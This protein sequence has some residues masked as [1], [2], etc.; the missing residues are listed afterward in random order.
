M[1]LGVLSLMASEAKALGH[2]FSPQLPSALDLVSKVILVSTFLPSYP[3]SIWLPGQSS[4][5][6]RDTGQSSRASRDMGQSSR[7]SRDTGQSPR[8]G[9]GTG[10]ASS[11]LSGVGHW[12]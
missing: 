2:R 1:T 4:H 6:G 7:V 12:L 10:W 8:M 9:W 3:A 11:R 5:V